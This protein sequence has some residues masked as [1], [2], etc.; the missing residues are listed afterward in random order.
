VVSPRWFRVSEVVATVDVSA[1][2]VVRMVVDTR[3]KTRSIH[4]WTNQLHLPIARIGC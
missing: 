4:A 1:I 3:M 2:A